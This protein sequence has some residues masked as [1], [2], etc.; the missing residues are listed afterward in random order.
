MPRRLMR[1][2]RPI[3]RPCSLS[4]VGIVVALLMPLG[5]LLGPPEPLLGL[6]VASREAL[7]GAFGVSVFERPWKKAKTLIFADSSSLFKVF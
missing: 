6:I 5:P 3:L 4:V 2:G 7:F 1:S